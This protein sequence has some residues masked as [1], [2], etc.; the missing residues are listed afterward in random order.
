M[1]N[2]DTELAVGRSVRGSAMGRSTSISNIKTT[3]G[4]IDTKQAE[5]QY[6]GV[7]EHDSTPQLY[8]GAHDSTPQLYLGVPEL[9]D[10]AAGQE[11]K[12]AGCEISTVAE[13]ISSIKSTVGRTVTEPAI[14][15]SVSKSAVGRSVSKPATV[16]VYWL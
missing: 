8:P 7:P 16:G 4:D 11:G 13:T 5:L 1:G 3:V 2:I 12:M 14:G 9:E 6:L 10:R 15:S